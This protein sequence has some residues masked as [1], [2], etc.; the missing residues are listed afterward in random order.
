MMMTITLKK[1]QLINYII[2]KKNTKIAK[3]MYSS[4]V[5][6]C[7][8]RGLKM[9]QVMEKLIEQCLTANKVLS[10]SELKIWVDA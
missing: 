3:G 1:F 2:V 10:F 5:A 8:L 7:T 4:V 9:I 6:I